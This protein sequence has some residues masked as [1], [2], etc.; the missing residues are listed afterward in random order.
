M[1]QTAAAAGYMVECLA[2]YAC[3]SEEKERRQNSTNYGIQKTNQDRTGA[4]SINT[5]TLGPFT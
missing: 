3:N 4:Y 5:Y 1:T 2:P